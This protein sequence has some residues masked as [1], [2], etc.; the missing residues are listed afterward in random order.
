MTRGIAPAA[1]ALA[2]TLVLTFA[3]A[4]PARTVMNTEDPPDQALTTADE[5][6]VSIAP[7]SYPIEASLVAMVEEE[8]RELIG[9]HLVDLSLNADQ[10]GLTVGVNGRTAS[11]KTK[12][13]VALSPVGTGWGSMT[14][15]SGGVS[16]DS[17]SIPDIVGRQDS[18]GKLYLYPGRSTG[19]FGAK[20]E[21][22][23]GF[24]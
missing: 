14:L 2:S 13:T 9:D 24:W 8:A 18:T 21:I 16:L 4:A 15:A 23:H 11:E 5:E 1:A 10:T 3:A 19:D 22:G 7:E 6:I 17:D 20:V 12:A